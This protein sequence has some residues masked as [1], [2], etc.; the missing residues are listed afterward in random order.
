LRSVLLV[1]TLVLLLAISSGHEVRG[2]N[3]PSGFSLNIQPGTSQV[4]FTIDIFQNLTAVVGSFVLP[5]TDSVLVGSNSTSASAT[6]QSAIQAKTPS[7][8]VKDLKLNAVSTAWFNTTQV[9]WLNIS[10]SFGL[11]EGSLGSGQGGQFDAAWRSFA[12]SSSINLAGFEVNTIGSAYL[13]QAAEALQH[14]TN[15]KTSVFTYHVNGAGVTQASLPVKAAAVSVLNFSSLATPLSRWTPAYNY[16]TNSV[17]WSLKSL[18][19]YSFEVTE[20]VIEAQP[21]QI[22]YLL[23]YSLHQASI[24]APLRSSISGDTIFVVFGDAT[25]TLMGLIIGSASIL[26]VGTT[27]YERRVLSRTPGKKTRR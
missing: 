13:V 20:T 14:L 2:N 21:A 22:H 3:Q 12:V 15:T 4:S 5:Q 23:S 25:E 11:E 27:F 10:A 17:T 6:F 1:A 24:T 19:T 26:A 18:P 9:Q 8:S 16:T 7:A